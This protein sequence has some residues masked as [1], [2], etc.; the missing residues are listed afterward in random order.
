MIE[1]RIGRILRERRMKIAVAESCTGGH[2]SNRIT[3][4]QGASDYFDVGFVTYSN[5]SKE[6]Y[7]FVP[8]EVLAEKGSVSSEVAKAMAEGLREATHADIALS[9][10][11]IAGPGGGTPGKPVGTVF[12]GLASKDGTFV[13]RFLFSGDRISIKEQTSEAALKLVLDYLEGRLR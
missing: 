9:V 6:L 12:V 13:N 5:D 2:I 8:E 10:T 11:G 7:L 3:N 1:T 4:I